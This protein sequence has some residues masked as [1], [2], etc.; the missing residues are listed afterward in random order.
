MF[1]CFLLP[2]SAFHALNFCT[3]IHSICVC[4]LSLSGF[5]TSYFCAFSRKKKSFNRRW[6]SPECAC[7]DVSPGK[8]HHGGARPCAGPQRPETATHLR[9]V[10]APTLVR[11]F[12]NRG[13]ALLWEWEF[14]PEG[15]GV[16]GWSDPAAPPASAADSTARSARWQCTFPGLMQAQPRPRARLPGGGY[17]DEIHPP[18]C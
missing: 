4:F 5:H 11:R 17:S 6:C 15:A 18:S 16:W 1:I 14:N 7:V 12:G 13:R 2:S 9:W 10:S 3:H 8:L